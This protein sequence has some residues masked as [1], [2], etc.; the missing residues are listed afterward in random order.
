MYQLTINTSI[1]RLS[2][3][4]SIPMDIGNKDY[5]EYLQWLDNGGVP[6]PVPIAPVPIPTQVDMRQARQALLQK[7]L[8]ATVNTAVAGMTGIDGEA[9]RIEWEFA[10][11]VQRDS[12][13]LISLST[14]LGFTE[15]QL[16]ELFILAGAL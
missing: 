7:G 9:A 6:Q 15:I 12:P 8:Y 5:R 4:A 10:P 1:L 16:D 2:D 13:L 3:S 14:A 11:V